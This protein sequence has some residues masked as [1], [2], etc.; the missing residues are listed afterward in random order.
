VV[1][2][3]IAILIGLLLPAVQKVRE[4]AARAQCGNQLKQLALACHNA[5]D[6]MNSLP[7]QFGNYPAGGVSGGYGP[8]LWHML[9]YM[10]QG[11]V[12][13]MAGGIANA[14]GYGGVATQTN[15]K[16]Y[17]CPSDPSVGSDGVL[18]KDGW[19]GSTYAGNWLVFGK[20]NMAPQMRG[21]TR[22]SEWEGSSRIPSSFAD[23]TSNTLLFTEKLA[24]CSQDGSQSCGPTSAGN[25][26]ARWDGLDYCAS[27]FAGWIMGPNAMFQLQPRMP[28]SGGNC[29]PGV[30]SS[31][32]TGGINASLADGSVRFVSSGVNP[33]SWWQACTPANGEV[34]NSDW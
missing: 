34:M 7:P 19:H 23:G 21:G 30:A 4:A 33:A 22:G 29:N 2:A 11:N 16:V 3:I 15:I 31:P 14:G 27:M 9:P 18:P 8:L 17:L 5:N 24:R 6:T 26:W 10:E 1:I 32:H 12:Y 25:M 20:T 13:N 28:D